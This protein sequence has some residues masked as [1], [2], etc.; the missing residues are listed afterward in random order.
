MFFLFGLSFLILRFIYYLGC[1]VLFKFRIAVS[2]II[3]LFPTVKAFEITLWFFSFSFFK[4]TL[5][6]SFKRVTGL[7]IH[8][9]GIPFLL[10]GRVAYF[11]AWF[12]L[13]V[14]KAFKA[15]IKADC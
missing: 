8:Y 2:R 3:F 6:S 14:F 1:F 12:L 5:F 4:L 11:S 13:G 7:L 9:I 10:I 15:V